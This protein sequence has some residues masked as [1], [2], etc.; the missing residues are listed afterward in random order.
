[1]LPA[2]QFNTNSHFLTDEAAE[3]AIPTVVDSDSE[4]SPTK[5]WRIKP[6]K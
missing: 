1:M 6:L 5:L 3:P 4:A 2:V